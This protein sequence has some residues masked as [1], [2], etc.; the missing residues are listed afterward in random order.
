MMAHYINII[1]IKA[2][3]SPCYTKRN[4]PMIKSLICLCIIYFTSVRY[5]LKYGGIILHS[6]LANDLTKLKCVQN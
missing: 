5:I 6:N 2:I 3:K 4:T 1:V